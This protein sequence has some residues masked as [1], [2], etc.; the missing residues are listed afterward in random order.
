MEQRY[1]N[2]PYEEFKGQPVEVD[3]TYVR[4]L[5]KTY[6]QQIVEN[7]QG[8]D[9]RGDLYVG[10]AGI[11]FMFLRLCQTNELVQETS[12]RE[13]A[14]LYINRAKRNAKQYSRSR[15]ERC[16]FLCGNAGIYAVSAAISE[17]TQKPD[18]LQ[19][20]LK[21]FEQ[22]FEACKPVN[23]SK[24]GGDEL[25]VGRAGFLSGVYWLNQTLKPKPFSSEAIVELCESVVK[26]GRQYSKERRST[27]PL[28]YQ[29]H[30]T[31]YLG[32]AHGLS[33]ILHMLLESPWFSIDSSG[34]IPIPKDYEAD[35]KDTIDAF[36]A[37]QE[38]DGN[39]PI[40]L[41]SDRKRNTEKRLVHWC[42]GAPGA[43][44]FL[45]RAYQIFNNEKYLDGCKR[46]ADLIWEKGLL[47]KGPSLCHG[48]SGNGYTFL[49]LYKVT[50]NPMYLYRAIKFA[51]FLTKSRF[52]REANTPDR[53]FSLYEG[54]AGAVC[55][56][57]DL[58]H[59]EQATFP[60]FR[61]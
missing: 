59:I 27:F 61:I 22:G 26:S 58:L 32:A 17:L 40:A 6:V 55:F 16:A 49:M 1:F 23:Y 24:H 20:D 43:V 3:E 14:Q 47:R 19:Q 4:N 30:G 52:I 34:A 31:E 50:Q 51:N 44:Y 39:F 41:A 46:A 35:I 54:I 37:L 29:Y 15:D 21:D 8:G 7:T 45:L 2:N 57:I 28:M 60:F 18:T 53:P 12:A 10:D 36:L 13:N 33:G 42:H 56:L 38:H 9:S 11:A 25:L 5:I 48:I